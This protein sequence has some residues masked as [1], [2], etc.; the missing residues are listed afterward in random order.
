MARSETGHSADWVVAWAGDRPQWAGAG[1][2]GLVHDATC[3][4]SRFTCHGLL[5]AN[6]RKWRSA[7]LSEILHDGLDELRMIFAPLGAGG[8][9]GHNDDEI[10]LGIDSKR[11]G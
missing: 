8:V 4:L 7:L 11:G 2:G 6:F 5:S 3:V 9:P 10:V 1:R